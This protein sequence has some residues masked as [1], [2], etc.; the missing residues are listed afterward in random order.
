[1][2]KKTGQAKPCY[3]LIMVFLLISTFTNCEEKKL[4]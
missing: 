2:K 4:Q 3:A 1:M